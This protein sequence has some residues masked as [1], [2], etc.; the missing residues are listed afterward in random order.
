MTSI[1]SSR[2]LYHVCVSV[3]K[4]PEH[5]HSVSCGSSSPKNSFGAKADVT[6]WKV[7]APGLGFE[8]LSHKPDR[9]NFE[10]VKA[11]THEKIDEN[12]LEAR[13]IDRKSVV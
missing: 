13:V 12:M 2:T 5:A 4:P 3:T 9:I 6:G 8:T 1:P 10:R 11:W 7:A